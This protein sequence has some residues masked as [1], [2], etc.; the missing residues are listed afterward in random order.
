MDNVRGALQEGSSGLDDIR[1]WQQELLGRM[2]WALTIVGGLGLLVS[3]FQ[4]F[5]DQEFATLAPYLGAYTI[6]LLVKFW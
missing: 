1:V 4:A 6:L 3:V 2:F 5:R